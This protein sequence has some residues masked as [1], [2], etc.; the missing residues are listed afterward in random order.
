[1]IASNLAQ[2]AAG[3]GRDAL[4]LLSGMG[5]LPMGDVSRSDNYTTMMRKMAEDTS[6]MRAPPTY[7][8]VNLKQFRR[9]GKPEAVPAS[10]TT[11][12]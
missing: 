11:C 6:P 10:R 2:A 8:T 4:G 7:H 1:M 5:I 3:F 12:F 9:T